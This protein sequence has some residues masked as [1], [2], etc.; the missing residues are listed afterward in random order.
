V[1]FFLRLKATK[2][3]TTISE[4]STEENRHWCVFLRR[5]AARRHTASQY[6]IARTLL[7]WHTGTVFSHYLVS[8]VIRNSKKT[9]SQI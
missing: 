2:R 1:C 8:F 7:A 3:H 5:Q 9:Q 6:K 4:D